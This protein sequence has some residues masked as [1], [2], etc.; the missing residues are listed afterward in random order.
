MSEIAGFAEH[1]DCAWEEIPPCV[2][3]K[4]H[5]IRLYQ[6][7]LPAAKDPELAAK[8]AA[9]EHL[10]HAMDED[11]NEQGMGFYWLCAACGYK[12]WYE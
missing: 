6:G 3:C 9:C 10:D 12:G 8:R 7:T 2:Y 11:G 1:R 4:D 5:G